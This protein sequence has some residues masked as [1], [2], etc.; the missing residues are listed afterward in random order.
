MIDGQQNVNAV[1]IKFNGPCKITFFEK[2]GSSSVGSL[3][4]PN[5]MKREICIFP[6]NAMPSG[7]RVPEYDY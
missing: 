1:S 6:E 2:S 4:N 7:P 5:C 3:H